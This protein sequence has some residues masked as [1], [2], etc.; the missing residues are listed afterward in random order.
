MTKLPSVT[1]VI[2]TYNE[3]E[4]IE[5]CLRAVD[6]QT[7]PPLEVLVVDGGS[8]DATR[9]IVE[10][11]TSARVLHNPNRR[12]AAAL[13]IGIRAAKGD[14][15]ARIDGHCIVEDDYLERALELL[16]TTGA[17]VVGGA[18][19]PVGS[20]AVQRGIVAAMRSRLGAGPARFHVGGRPGW[21]D[22]VYL[23]VFARD[24][25]L[26]VGG[27]AEDVGV[28]EDSELAIRMQPHGGVWFDPSLR[29]TY[30]P[31]ATVGAV[32][33]QFYWYGRSRALT[34]RRHPR[35]IRPRQLAAPALILLLMSPPRKLV[36]QAYLSVVVAR[37]ATEAIRD[38]AA[39]AVMALT[40]P[41][42][43]LP[44]GAGFIVGLMSPKH[45][46]A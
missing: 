22:T 32:A 39:A 6:Q 29:S 26:R 4:H 12:Q 16:S 10:N 42:M 9:R 23:G 7:V 18:M 21:V 17:A 13:N 14:V 1:V 8:Q 11:H 5:A 19:R 20:G 33:R 41:A 15:I 28:N 35:A 34:A 46:A 37:S 36:T 25:A 3:E 40:L 27:Y 24:V 2:P 43:H 30:V 45:S 44:W 38:P 31:R